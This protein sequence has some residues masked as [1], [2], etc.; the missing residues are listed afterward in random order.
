MSDA[1]EHVRRWQAAGLID[2]TLARRILA[3]EGERAPE[4]S[5][6]AT[7]PGAFENRPGALEVLLYLGFAVAGAGAFFLIAVNW[8]DLES[9]ARVMM[10]AVPALLALGAGALLRTFEDPGVRRAGQLAWLLSAALVPGTLAVLLNEYGGEGGDT[11]GTVILIALAAFIYALV[12]WAFEPGH[13]QV[14]AIAGSLMFLAQAIGNWPDDF[15]T[16]LAGSSLLLG[17]GVGLLLTEVGL[18]T[19]RVSCRALFAL[20]TFAGPYQAGIAGPFVFELLTFVAAAGLIALG[21]ARASFVLVVVG[22]AGVF[23]ALVTF[24]FEHFSD[25]LGAPVALILSGALLIAGVL[26]LAGARR[27]LPGRRLA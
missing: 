21:V 16:A 23:V 13:P 5:A 15:S 2:E 26:V 4:A 12:L 8:V 9:W 24:V 14:I 1:T 22:T 11:R 19:P 10:I 18:M 7:A 17:A 3:F 6:P 20:E 27:A 25:D